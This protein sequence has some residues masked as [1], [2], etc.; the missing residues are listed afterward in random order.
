MLIKDYDR[1]LASY[2]AAVKSNH[3]TMLE[4]KTYSGVS[5]DVIRPPNLLS[6][7][8]VGLDKRLNNEVFVYYSYVPTLWDGQKH[9]ST[10]PSSESLFFD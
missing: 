6:I 7:F 1:R 4:R 5:W 2:N 3:E 10:N 9:G 8:N